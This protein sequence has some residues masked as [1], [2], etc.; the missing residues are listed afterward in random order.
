MT[1]ATLAALSVWLGEPFTNLYSTFHKVNLFK[2]LSLISSQ[3]SL[4]FGTILMLVGFK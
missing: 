3:T 2:I 1:V 4:K